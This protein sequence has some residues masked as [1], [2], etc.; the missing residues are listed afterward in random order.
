MLTLLFL[1]PRTLAA[2]RPQGPRPL[3]GPASSAGGSWFPQHL[4]YCCKQGK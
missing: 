4:L 2:P 3:S 1:L